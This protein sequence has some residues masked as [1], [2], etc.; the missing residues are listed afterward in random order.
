MGKA[1]DPFNYQ[2]LEALWSEVVTALTKLT[3]KVLT[4]VFKPTVELRT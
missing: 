4:E 3:D 1:L 2:A